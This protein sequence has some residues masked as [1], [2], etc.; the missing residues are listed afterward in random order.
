MSKYVGNKIITWHRK[1]KKLLHATA[2]KSNKFI[3]TETYS[4]YI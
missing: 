2:L 4:A 3:T 1:T